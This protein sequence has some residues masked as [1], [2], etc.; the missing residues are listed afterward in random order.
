LTTL[1]IAKDARRELKFRVSCNHSVGVA[2]ILAGD[3]SQRG[4]PSVN[5]PGSV[6][7]R[8]KEQSGLAWF[9]AT[10]G[11]LCGASRLVAGQIGSCWHRADSSKWNPLTRTCGKKFWNRIE[12][13]KSDLPPAFLVF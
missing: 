3:Q 6:F 5:L 12:N 11:T 9:D 1:L 10:V 2:G 4:V 8:G 7:G 13:E